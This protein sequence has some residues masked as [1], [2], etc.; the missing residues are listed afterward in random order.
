MATEVKIKV[1]STYAQNGTD[2]DSQEGLKMES[3]RQRKTGK[4]INDP[5]KNL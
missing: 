1:A 3:Y 5:E 4:A 2:K